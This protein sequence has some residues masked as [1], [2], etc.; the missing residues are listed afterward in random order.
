VL[1]EDD[2]ETAIVDVV[3]LSDDSED[4]TLPPTTSIDEPEDQETRPRLS[5]DISVDAAIELRPSA[6][7]TETESTVNNVATDETET[8]EF[9]NSPPSEE[10]DQNPVI[11]QPPAEDPI[12][13]APIG[14]GNESELPELSPPISEALD[15]FSS[16]KGIIIMRTG[17][18]KLY[19]LVPIL[20][21]NTNQPV[22]PFIDRNDSN[23]FFG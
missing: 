21:K 14:G 13:S 22:G 19:T 2:T 4:A 5:V 11:A 23:R 17:E 1:S 6:D 20:D 8:E 9:I 10:A 15:D 12:T 3:E 16:E 18:D 7:E